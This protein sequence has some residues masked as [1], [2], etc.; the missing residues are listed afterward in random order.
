MSISQFTAIVVIYFLK[1][2]EYRYIF[3]IDSQGEK[4]IIIQ[5][6]LTTLTLYELEMRNK[7][8][9]WVLNNFHHPTH[10]PTHTHHPVLLLPSCDS[11]QQIL[12]GKFSGKYCKWLLAELCM[13]I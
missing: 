2:N 6:N 8:V 9:G 1:P 10:T 4:I 13:N 5:V 11:H 7:I 3:K 12:L